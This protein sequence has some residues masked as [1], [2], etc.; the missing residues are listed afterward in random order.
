MLPDSCFQHR[1]DERRE[2]KTVVKHL[3]RREALMG[4]VGRRVL[5]S[6]YLEDDGDLAFLLQTAVDYWEMFHKLPAYDVLC[7]D[8]ADHRNEAA[9]RSPGAVMPES[10]IEL[11][12]Y[13]L[14]SWYAPQ[15]W[16]DEWAK[17]ILQ[18]YLK[19]YTARQLVDKLR[20]LDD[21]AVIED[22][23]KN[24]HTI[25]RGNPF[26]ELKETTAW[27]NIWANM[28]EDERMP[29]GCNFIDLA[30]DGGLA[31]KEA[32]LF[33]APSGGGKTTLGMQMAAYRVARQSHVVYIATEQPL[34]GDM[35][36]R[37][38][39][40]ATGATRK[41]LRGGPQAA[42]PEIRRRLEMAAQ[43]WKAY[44]HF[45]DCRKSQKA[46]FR[47]ED[48]FVPIDRLLQAG[49]HIDFII[50]DW[51]GRLRNRMIMQM[52]S[53]SDARA[54]YA[55]SEWLDS[56]IDGT[57]ERDSRLMVLHQVKGAAA[58]K[59]PAAR[60][61]THDAQEDSNLNNLFEFGFAVSKLNSDNQC[62]IN[63]DKARSTSRTDG[64]LQ[65]DGERGRF[66]TIDATTMDGG[67]I[68][69]GPIRKSDI[70]KDRDITQGQG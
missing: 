16:S 27:D 41:E 48:I 29:L 32:M 70:I 24:A 64:Y 47:I 4:A 49:C 42:S 15:T 51:W 46:D 14:V 12:R 67:S 31:P 54:R 2:I 5:D 68:P 50:L 62:R 52:R 1:L 34:E 7:A 28:H 53:N 44:F 19:R 69:S 10:F 8:L 35:S 9:Q 63:C 21:L 11:Y 17:L 25:I 40:L 38:A 43:D 57:K 59:G 55:T 23:Y 3:I 66:D 36:M 45:I 6:D 37:Q 39:M 61:T 56:L 33:V 30:L 20:D 18:D 26:G 22:T 13:E 60:V 58:G 65:L